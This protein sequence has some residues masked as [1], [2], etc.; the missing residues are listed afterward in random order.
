MTIEEAIKH[1]EEVAESKESQ[2]QRGAWEKDSFTERKCKKGA[3][4]HRQL[5]EWLKD[6]KR[7]LNAIEDIKVDIQ[8]YRKQCDNKVWSYYIESKKEAYND[9]LVLIDKHTSGK[10]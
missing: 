1:C 9:I 8:E 4:E 10:E 2:L 3:A 7:L 6:Y 5:A